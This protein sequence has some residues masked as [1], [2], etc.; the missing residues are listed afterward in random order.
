MNMV[1]GWRVEYNALLKR[2]AK[3]EEYLDAKGRTEEEK[4]KWKPEYEKITER[5]GELLQ[6]IQHYKTENVMGGF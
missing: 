4:E 6:L 1:E 5:L 3:A 2:E